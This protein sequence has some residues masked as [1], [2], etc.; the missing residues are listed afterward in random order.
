MNF[1][2]CNTVL[3]PW[4]H[5]STPKDKAQ[6]P[7]C[8]GEHYISDPSF[9]FHWGPRWPLDPHGLMFPLRREQAWTRSVR[10]T[11]GERKR[12][13][14]QRFPTGAFFKQQINFLSSPGLPMGSAS[15]QWALSQAR[16][17][18]S[19]VEH[20]PLAILIS[21]VYVFTCPCS[22]P[23]ILCSGVGCCLPVKQAGLCCPAD[24]LHNVYP[25]LP[26]Y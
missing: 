10:V 22:S 14:S 20:L 12:P 7:S 17:T 6:E 23:T 3:H 11:E 26:I 5:S 1:Q 4:F 8:L 15:S 25:L 21:V 13:F 16:L 2:L 24:Q 9:P 18:V 19:V